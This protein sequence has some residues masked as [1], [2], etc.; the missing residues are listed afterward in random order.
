MIPS[1]RTSARAAH[2]LTATVLAGVLTYVVLAL[3]SRSVSAA[4]FDQFSVFWSIA[5][6]IGFGFFLPVEQESARISR[7]Q[8]ESP[9]LYPVMMRVTVVLVGAVIVLVALASPAL[10]GMLGMPPMLVVA[11]A[12]VALAS[13]I[14]FAGRGRLLAESR[15]TAFSNVLIADTLLRVALFAAVAVIA[16]TIAGTDPETL[17]ALALIAAIVIAHAWAVPWTRWSPIDR[18]LLVEFRRAVLLLVGTSLC[19]QILVNAGPILIQALADTPGLAGAFQASSTLARI[20]LAM[21]TPIQAM[22]VGPLAAMAIAGD[23]AAVVRLMRRVSAAAIVAAL[24]GAVVG[25]L[26]G[27]WIVDLI[28]GSGRALSGPDIALLVAGVV[29]HVALIILTQ[30][31]IAMGH[32]RAAFLTWLIALVSATIVFLMVNALAGPVLGVELGFGVGSLVGAAVAF[33]LVSR[34]SRVSGSVQRLEKEV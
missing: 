27:P 6:I 15:M 18:G 29:V 1:R 10:I 11:S 9:S 14:Q 26:L 24:A 5:L 2:A 19:A 33:G 22:L 25:W 23:H 31:V 17:F 20:P 30:A 32:H 4:E 12:L 8:P 28:F 13:G 16:T 21:I 3:V 34:L 7:A